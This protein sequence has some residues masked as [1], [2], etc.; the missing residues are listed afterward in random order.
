VPSVAN[1][2]PSSLFFSE[3][4][5]RVTLLGLIPGATYWLSGARGLI[6]LH[7]EFKVAPGQVLDLGDITV[8]PRR[9]G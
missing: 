6:N 5:G 2:E 8:K 7:R 3:A 9:Q 1:G 4:K